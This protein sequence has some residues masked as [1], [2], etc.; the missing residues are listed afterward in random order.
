LEI[1]IHYDPLLGK[2]IVWGQDRATAIR[3]C[4]RA[5]EEYQVD[6]IK[7]NIEFLLWALDEPTFIDGSYD[8][9]FVDRNFNP[10][11]LRRRPDDLE[12][13][14]IAGSITAYRRLER[15]NLGRRSEA[16]GN[17]WREAA[18]AEGF[19]KARQGTLPSW[20]GRGPS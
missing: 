18:R 4:K 20:R 19:R 9:T 14:A 7:T 10:S 3:R 6:G 11:G 1:P 2:M 17:A 5:L 12:L 16:R 8:T 13:A 15:M